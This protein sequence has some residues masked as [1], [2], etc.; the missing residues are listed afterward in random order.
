MT[1]DAR[2]HHHLRRSD[3]TL[4]HPDTV[5]RWDGSEW[6]FNINTSNLLAGNTYYYQIGLN[7]GSII[8][9]R[10]GLK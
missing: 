8:Q 1:T 10:F 2:N 6:I 4:H 9:F 5:F 3:S 7:D